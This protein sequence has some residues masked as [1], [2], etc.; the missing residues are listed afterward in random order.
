M[1]EAGRAHGIV[2]VH[3]SVVEDAEADGDASLTE[4]GSFD[5]CVAT[6]RLG[7]VLNVVE[8]L[9]HL[10]GAGAVSPAPAKSTFPGGSRAHLP[11]AAKVLELNPAFALQQCM[12]AMQRAAN[13][14]A[15]TTEHDR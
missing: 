5:G 3:D 14:A 1:F 12:D 10:V 6:S 15:V 9:R 4:Q 13:G 7:C 8:G 11:R 2:L